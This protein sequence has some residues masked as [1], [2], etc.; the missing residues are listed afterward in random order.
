MS[1]GERSGSPAEGIG[2]GLAT[3][4]VGNALAAGLGFAQSVVVVRALGVAEYGL[5]GILGSVAAICANAVDLRLGDATMRRFFAVSVPGRTAGGLA[6]TSEPRGPDPLAALLA[7]AIAQS[8]L[9]AVLA[10]ATVAAALALVGL[11]SSARL[12]LTT[13][14]AFALSEALAYG[15]R[16]VLF[17]IRFAREP[18]TLAAC[19]VSA[20]ALRAL[21]VVATLL[22][23]PSIEG[24]VAGLVLAGLAAAALNAAVFAQV[25]LVRRGLRTTVRSVRGELRSLFDRR[26]ELAALNAI[27]LQNLLHRGADVLVVGLLA[28]EREAGLYKLARSLSD[29]LYVAYDAAAKT[30]Q[31]LVLQL[32]AAEDGVRLR[33]LVRRMLQV[34]G[35]GTCA[36]L[37]LELLW[38]RDL[39]AWLFGA[40]FVAAVP[41]IV[42]LTVPAFFVFGLFLWAWPLVIHA[43]EVRR[44]AA[45]GFAAVLLGQYGLGVGGAMLG[46]GGGATW[47]AA[48]YLTSELLLW[49]AFGPR[50]ASLLRVA[51][52]SPS[53][54]TVEEAGR[55][56]LRAAGGGR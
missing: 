46:F 4:L 16:Y 6:A 13:L 34:A 22:V 30:L 45:V 50:A 9:G 32:R 35:L 25:W 12:S 21:L 14:V 31:P 44:Y 17:T 2:A 54:A 18:R 38:L 5:Y 11:F 20:A 37:V 41:A 48:G 47:L 7:G 36:L 56:V 49:A 52:G 42:L 15:G 55:L 23:W 40:G 1:R 29:A 27:N 51:G 28:G 19:E 26:R 53:D 8:L 10:V 24:L 33:E 39:V 3:A 43:G